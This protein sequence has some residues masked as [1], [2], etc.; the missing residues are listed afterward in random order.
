M[1]S[2]GS[3]EESERQK[4]ETHDSDENLTDSTSAVPSSSHA[5]L[6]SESAT[7]I[8]TEKKKDKSTCGTA[9]PRKKFEWTNEIRLVV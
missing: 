6:A 2:K 8:S 3:V 4:E 5:S 7:T 1:R 9:G